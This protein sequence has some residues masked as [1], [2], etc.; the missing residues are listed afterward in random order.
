MVGLQKPKRGEGQGPRSSWEGSLET[1]C[2]KLWEEAL[3]HWDVGFRED[4]TAQIQLRRLQ[5]AEQLLLCMPM[6]FVLGVA[7]SSQENREGDVGS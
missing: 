6:G 5:A 2:S 1:W 7:G 4:L 3:N